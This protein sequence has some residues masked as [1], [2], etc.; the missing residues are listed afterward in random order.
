MVNT[1][2]MHQLDDR[3]NE[4]GLQTTTAKFAKDEKNLKF[5]GC[6]FAPAGEPLYSYLCD[7]C[8]PNG[9]DCK[10]SDGTI[11]AAEVKCESTNANQDKCH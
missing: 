10:W 2:K 3:V 4:I 1:A 8:C 6:T 11:M 9:D 5:Y 7:V